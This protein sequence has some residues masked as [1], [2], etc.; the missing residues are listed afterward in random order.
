MTQNLEL[1]STSGATALTN[2][3]SNVSSSGYSLTLSSNQDAYKGNS[4]HYG[5]YYTFAQAT[6]GSGSTTS[7][8]DAQYD[9][10]PKNW[11]L[12]SAS[13]SATTS[14]F[15]TMLNNYISTG[16]WSS[17]YW[18]GVT[19]TN[20]TNAPV[21]LVFSGYWSSGSLLGQ[22]NFGDWWSSTSNGSS[23]AFDLVANSNGNVY[24]RFNLYQTNGF[25]V[26]CLVPSS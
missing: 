14:E 7:G 12:P 21:S 11:R 13:T 5:N 15:Y 2:E 19:T 20:F 9:I 1:G 22:G 25:T 6:A 4:N 17:T 18:T 24:P 23:N 10:C 8:V 26:R 16:T 3:L